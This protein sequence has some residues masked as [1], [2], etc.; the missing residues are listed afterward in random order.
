MKKI[1]QMKIY[2]VMLLICLFA[3][4]LSG[5]GADDIEQQDA[6][7]QYGINCMTEARYDD[8][9]VAFQGALNQSRGKVT[10]REIDIVYYK[11]EALF[12]GERYEEA[13]QAYDAIIEYNG[14]T[15]AYYLR[16]CLKMKMGLPE[17]AV[18][19]FKEA[20]SRDKNNYEL[21]IGI[22]EALAQSDL[23]GQGQS[24]L[25]QALEIRGDK[26]FDKM[27]KGRIYILL[28]DTAS[29]ITYLKEAVDKGSEQAVYYLAL[30]Y[31]TAGDTASADA[32]YEIYL[33]SQIADAKELCEMGE[34]Q[35]KN[36]NYTLALSYF[37]AALEQENLRNKPQILRDMAVSYENLG[38]FT[39]AKNTLEEYLEYNPD[40]EQAK[41][42]MVFLETR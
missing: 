15:D 42:E 5:C 19:D 29:A 2:S 35:M 37:E 11:A 24:Y 20:V 25:N 14:A 28:G 16:G 33:E 13:L 38:N 30:A 17:D 27:E 3:G 1:L 23:I 4:M 9:V 12:L 32:N 7:C 36:K 6:F 22:Y 26:A 40:D 41:R 34:R 18:A 10:A 8:A 31:E 39:M 21:Y